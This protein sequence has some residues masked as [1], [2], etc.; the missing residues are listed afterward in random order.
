MNQN[1][2]LQAIAA[3]FRK[4]TE[5]SVFTVSMIA[6]FLIMLSI[7]SL[8][9]KLILKKKKVGNWQQEFEQ[10]L[11]DHDLTINEIDLLE[12]LTPFLINPKRKI[13][14]LSNRNIFLSTL[15]LWKTKTG[16]SSIYADRLME[17]LFPKDQNTEQGE[18]LKPFGPGCPIRYIA[19]DGKSYAGILEKKEGNIL[20]LSQIRRIDIQE[21]SGLGHIH[22]QDNSGIRTYRVTESQKTG[23]NALALTIQ[24]VL[25]VKKNKIT[26]SDVSLFVYGTRD[27]I[28]TRFIQ[29]GKGYG[30]IENP[31]EK[32]TTGQML[33]VNFH[34]EKNNWYRINAVVNGVSSDRRFARLKFGYLKKYQPA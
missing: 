23:S 21:K 29:L 2:L 7:V 22:I 15:N 9:F 31:E 3:G 11:R 16:K 12:E 33:Q 34:G 4:A 19:K 24:R 17:K 27:A 25:P 1:A 30:I 32:L 5:N 28:K 13:L 10:S 14:V 6:G 8:L 18:K 20:F 26:I